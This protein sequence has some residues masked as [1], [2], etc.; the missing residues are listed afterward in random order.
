MGIFCENENINTG[1][2][3]KQGLD[4]LT[5]LFRKGNKYSS[6]STARSVLSKLLP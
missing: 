4:F 2:T 1:I 3:L 5:Y 6:F